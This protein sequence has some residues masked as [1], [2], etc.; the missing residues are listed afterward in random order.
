MHVKE[1]VEVI[2]LDD[3]HEFAIIHVKA[4]VRRVVLVVVLVVALVVVVVVV[5]VHVKAVVKAV[6]AQV[7]AQIASLV[8]MVHA[9]VVANGGPIIIKICNL[10]R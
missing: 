2:A 5:V 10:C 6:V 1:P 9:K 4:D 8:V 7:V 3:A